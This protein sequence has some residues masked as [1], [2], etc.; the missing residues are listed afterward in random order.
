MVNFRDRGDGRF[1]ATARDALLDRDGRRQAF[2]QVDIGL[3][4]L[5]HELPRVGRH[6]VEKTALAFREEE[7]EGE[8]RFARAAQAG[9]HDHLVARNR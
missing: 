5:L 1:A 3:F 9:D 8:G 4:Q 7:V 2:D 6:A